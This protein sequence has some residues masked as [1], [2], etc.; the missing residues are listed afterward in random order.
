M[1]PVIKTC[2]PPIGSFLSNKSDW[3][4]LVISIFCPQKY[5]T[6]SKPETNN[7]SLILSIYLHV[8]YFSFHFY[9]CLIF[10]SIFILSFF[11]FVYLFIYSFIYMFLLINLFDIYFLIYWLIR[12]YTIYKKTIHLYYK[13][14][15]YSCISL[16]ALRLIHHVSFCL[17]W[18]SVQ[19][20]YE[21]TL[22]YHSN[23]VVHSIVFFSK[24]SSYSVTNIS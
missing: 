7:L 6:R 17:I 24:V 15:I 13:C 12:R 10:L 2:L 23:S 14:R 9:T 18:T 22:K 4:F 11:T 8:F 16:D 1:I 20:V 21:I 5:W 19:L 3:I